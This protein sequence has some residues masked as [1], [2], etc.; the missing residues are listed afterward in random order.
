MLA[1]G[2]YP[3]ASALLTIELCKSERAV[4]CLLTPSRQLLLNVTGSIERESKEKDN[5][6]TV[7]SMFLDALSVSYSKHLKSRTVV[8]TVLA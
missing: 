4:K 7:Q 1:E 5:F 6:F 2:S 8:N 3:D